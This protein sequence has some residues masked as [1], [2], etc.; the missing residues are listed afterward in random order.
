MKK[1]IFE[2]QFNNIE[3]IRI[4]ENRDL[5]FGLRLN[6]NERVENFPKKL[7]HKIFSEI[8][9][10]ALATYHDQNIIYNCLE[11]FFKISRSHFLITSGIDGAIK[12][13]LE[14]FCRPGH[15]ICFPEY[16]YAM[17]EVYSKLF[18]L[19]NI[20]YIDRYKRY[21]YI[22]IIIIISFLYYICLKKKY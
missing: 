13:I 10:H 20:R 11:D 5:K 8:P 17:Y 1:Y 14:V 21:S 6:R 4:P 22:K 12:N 16:T 9:N 3:R 19:K 18:K 7:F 15:T 2:Q